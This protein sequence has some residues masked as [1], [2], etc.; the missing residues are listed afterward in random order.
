MNTIENEESEKYEKPIMSAKSSPSH[1][2]VMVLMLSLFTLT[3]L[4]ITDCL[5]RCLLH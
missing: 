4:V 2:I 3:H 1:F 5:V